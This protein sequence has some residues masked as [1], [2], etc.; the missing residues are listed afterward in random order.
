MFHYHNYD[1]KYYVQGRKDKYYSESLVAKAEREVLFNQKF[2]YGLGSIN[3]IGDIILRK[4]L[5]LK[6]KDI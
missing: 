1:R 2:S 3:T 4:H 5:T 6:Q